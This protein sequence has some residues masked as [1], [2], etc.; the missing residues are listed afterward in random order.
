[1]LMTLE[2]Q[3]N[4][5]DGLYEHIVSLHTTTFKKNLGEFTQYARSKG[6]KG[7]VLLDYYNIKDMIESVKTKT[8]TYQW[9]SKNDAQR[10]RH[11]GI[12]PAIA[13]MNPKNDCVFVCSLSISLKHLYVNCIKFKDLDV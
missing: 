2:Q 8:F 4:L 3:K 9:I 5:Y 7:I 1:M 13:S 11:N 12:S 6:W 10:I